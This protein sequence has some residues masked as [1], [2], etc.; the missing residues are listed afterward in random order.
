MAHPKSSVMTPEEKASVKEQIKELRLKQKAQKAHR[1]EVDKA[2]KTDVL[3]LEKDAKATA[4]E[5]AKLEGQIAKPKAAPAPDA[6]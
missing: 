1:K 2:Y 6:E 3:A 5:L 4:K